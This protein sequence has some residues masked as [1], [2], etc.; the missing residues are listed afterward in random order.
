MLIGTLHGSKN[1]PPA[2][3]KVKDLHLVMGT[4]LLLPMVMTCLVRQ[5]L[6]VTNIGCTNMP[7]I[8]TISRLLVDM[9]LDVFKCRTENDITYNLKPHENVAFIFLQDRI[10]DKIGGYVYAIGADLKINGLR[11]GIKK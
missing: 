1:I 7:V 8:E 4:E 5:Q 9:P 11:F 10:F 6:M 2:P 3:I